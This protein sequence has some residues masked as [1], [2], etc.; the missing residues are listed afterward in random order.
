MDRPLL[1][2]FSTFWGFFVALVFLLCCLFVSCF[3]SVF[4]ASLFFLL[5]CFLVF[6]LICYSASSLV[7]FFASLLF[8]LLSTPKYK[9]LQI[10]CDIKSVS[11]LMILMLQIPHKMSTIGKIELQNRA[12]SFQVLS[13]ANTTKVKALASLMGSNSKYHTK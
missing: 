1:S 8:R 10:P 13:A 2:A 4:F 12:L 6:L 9:V 5:L 11:F 7:C 3:A